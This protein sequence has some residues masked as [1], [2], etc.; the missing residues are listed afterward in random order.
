MG[1]YGLILSIRSLYTKKGDS[2]NKLSPFLVNIR[3]HRLKRPPLGI[4]YLLYCFKGSI[5]SGNQIICVFNANG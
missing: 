2:K 1:L 4:L 3:R 5:Q